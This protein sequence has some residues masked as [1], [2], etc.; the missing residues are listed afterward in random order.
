MAE[1][2]KKN[3]KLK[4][5]KLHLLNLLCI[6]HKQVVCRFTQP[7]DFPYLISLFVSD[8]L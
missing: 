1:M 7:A 5:V 8:Y 4:S 6:A 3:G 2:A